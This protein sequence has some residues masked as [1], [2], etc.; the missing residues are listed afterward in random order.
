MVSTSNTKNM[1]AKLKNFTSNC[2]L[3][4]EKSFIP[5]SYVEV[6]S[7][8]PAFGAKIILI[9]TAA[10]AK[11]VDNIMNTNKKTNSFNHSPFKKVYLYLLYT[12]FYCYNSS[13]CELLRYFI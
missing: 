13:C 1:I 5:H 6:F 10:K 3:E 8:F 2:I 9:T 4:S 11:A 7:S 12:K